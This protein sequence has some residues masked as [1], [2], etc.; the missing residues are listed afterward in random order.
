MNT[1]TR[2]IIARFLLPILSTLAAFSRRDH[3]RLHST[4]MPVSRY[5]VGLLR[6]T[7]IST[8][9][10]IRHTTIIV[11]QRFRL[12]IISGSIA[13]GPAVVYASL[14]IL[15]GLPTSTVAING[16]FTFL[17]SRHESEQV[18]PQPYSNVKVRSYL[19]SLLLICTF[20]GCGRALLR[21][22]SIRSPSL[23]LSS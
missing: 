8:N 3:T 14:V 22:S 19:P 23:P 12:P 6:S 21:V 11:G 10:T 4:T 13:G 17:G 7:K 2:W 5:C 16:P 18:P 20:G 1:A 9:A 15:K